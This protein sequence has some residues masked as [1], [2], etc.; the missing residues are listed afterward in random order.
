[1]S[2]LGENP[3]NSW[4]QKWDFAIMTLARQNT[5]KALC[6]KK[7]DNGAENDEFGT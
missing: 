6:G 2:G 5:M 3:D 4:H 7:K 1:M